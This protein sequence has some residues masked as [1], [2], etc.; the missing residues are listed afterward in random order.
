N[1]TTLDTNKDGSFF[2]TI[3]ING[4]FALLTM[5]KVEYA[6]DDLYN[7]FAHEEMAGLEREVNDLRFFPDTDGDGY[8]NWDFSLYELLQMQSTEERHAMPTQTEIENG[9]TTGTFNTYGDL[10]FI[11]FVET[12]VDSVFTPGGSGTGTFGYETIGATKYT[13]VKDT[14]S[15]SKFTISEDG[16]LTTIFAYLEL[17]GGAKNP[18]TARAAIYS[19]SS[20]SPNTLLGESGQRTITRTLQWWDFTFSPPISLDA[21]TPYWLVIHTATKIDMYGDIGSANQRSYNDDAYSDNAD[22]PFNLGDPTTQDNVQLSIYASYD[23]ASSPDSNDLIAEIEWSVSDTV[24]SMDYLQWD[25]RTN[26]SA[27]VDFYVWNYTR[28]GY[29]LQTG[30]SPLVLITD[31]YDEATNTVKVKFDCDSPSSAFT[32]YIDMLRIDYFFSLGGEVSNDT[33]DFYALFDENTGSS[34]LD[35][36]SNYLGILQG[37][38]SWTSGIHN[39]SL[40]FDGDGSPPTPG[41][42]ETRYVTPLQ[43][44]FTTSPGNLDYFGDLLSVDNNEVKIISEFVPGG[45]STGTFGYESVGGARRRI[46][47][48]NKQG[49]KFTLT[50]A[51][52]V[53]SI[54]VWG[55]L[56]NG[57]NVRVGIYSDYNGAPDILQGSEEF[58]MA[59]SLQ[60]WMYTLTTPISLGVGDWWI[61]AGGDNRLSMYADSGSPNQRAYNSDPYG[62]G[63]QN[64][65]GAPSYTSEQ[66]SIYASYDIASSP[67]S[68]E[69][70][71]DIEWK[72]DDSVASM[73]YLN[74]SYSTNASATVNFYVWNYAT[75]GYDLQTGGSPLALTTDYYDG[76][77]NTVK[78]RFECSSTNSYELLIDQL[79]IE[80]NITVGQQIDYLDYDLVQYGDIMD[81]NLGINTEFVVTAWVYPTF[82]SSTQNPNGIK[83]LFFSKAG[84][85]ELG[86]NESGV[87]QVYMNTFYNETTATYGVLGSIGLGKWTYIAVRYNDSNVDVLIGTSWYYN[88]TGPDTEPWNGGGNLASGGKFSIGGAEDI[89]SCF[90]GAIDE[91]SVFN[92]SITNFEI[93]VHH[94]VISIE[95]AATKE[96]GFGGWTPII[97]S[98]EIIDGYINFQANITSGIIDLVEFY[99]TNYE[100]SS[101]GDPIPSNWSLLYSINNAQSRNSFVIDSH[102]LPDEDSWYFIIKAVDSYQHPTFK[103]YTIPFAINH[104][105]DTIEFYYDDTN[106]RINQNSHIG[107]VPLDGFE[108]YINTTDIYINYSNSW[109]LLNQ[110][111]INYSDISSNYNLID[112]DTLTSWI[113][114]KGLTPENYIVN[115]NISLSLNYGPEFD[116]YSYNYTLNNII[117]DIKGPDISLDYSPPYTLDLGKTYSNTSENILTGAIDFTDSDFDTVR[118]EYSYSISSDWIIYDTFLNTSRLSANFSMN[119]LNLKDDIID[120]RFIAVDDLGNIATLTDSTYWIIK[121]FDNHKDFIVE[122]LDDSFVY[123]L[124]QFDEID[125]TEI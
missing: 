60:W 85:F 75:V 12:S 49:S 37:N 8:P 38:T 119:I 25:Y 109:D 65:F 48:N 33:L 113:Q 26:P 71:T 23:I 121:D 53:T 39:S 72:V 22:D 14:K 83:N 4:S 17:G 36:I 112:L 13:R 10:E 74:W 42:N 117:L 111:P 7:Q 81:D 35:D 9:I 92:K 123:S 16:D 31:Y 104:F 70:L 2:Y 88:A 50:E 27:T 68:Y 43:N 57:G 62:D 102:S 19:D 115:F 64:P 91:V 55:K 66:L 51:G 56:R 108:S 82:F 11:D 99:V 24:Q 1:L 122:Y 21:N 103:I 40:L 69:I 86:I 73:E 80:H 124:N 34:T 63:F 79:R 94:G 3:Q 120:F 29:D 67:D 41:V 107:V 110:V 54:S 125:I 78:V 97:T 90:T 15:G 52:T 59:D 89:E 77:T 96:N 98:G 93:E 46:N 18:K 101:L 32:L 30:G 47:G 28:V 5:A 87:L 114:N 45:G 58:I 84:N 105:N 106:G 76:A 95:I 61:V 116:T 118:L 20:G 100:P 6:G 44:N